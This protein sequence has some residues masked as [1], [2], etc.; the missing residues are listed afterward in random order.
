MTIETV[1]VVHLALLTFWGGIVATE[2]V[3]EIYPTRHRDHHPQTIVFHYWIDLLV[4][5]PAILG[6]VASGLLLTLLSWPLS[7]LHWLKIAC[8]AGAIISNVLCIA[9]V[10]RRKRQ[11]DAGVPDKELWQQTRRVFLCLKLGLPLALVAAGLGFRL[12][13]ERLHG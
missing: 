1:S 11:M 10:L 7:G 2:S 4:E 13:F 5:L 9:L 12:A 8:A 3:L 6:V